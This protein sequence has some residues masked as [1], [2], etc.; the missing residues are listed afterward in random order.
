MDVAKSPVGEAMV[1]RTEEVLGLLREQSA[2]YTRLESFAARQRSL[3][4]A[5]DTAPL[6]MLLADRQRL[7]AEL[8]RLATR[9]APVRRG[10]TLFRERCSASQRAG[11]DGLISVVSQRLPP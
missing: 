11:A 6:L 10:W 8:T 5:D 2:L 3:V 4:R 7:S 1:E 9:L